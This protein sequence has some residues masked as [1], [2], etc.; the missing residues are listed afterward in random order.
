MR[1]FDDGRDAIYV[2][3]KTGNALIIPKDKISLKSRV[4]IGAVLTT[5]V[6]DNII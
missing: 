3:P 5:R 6:I 4:A 1:L 2:I